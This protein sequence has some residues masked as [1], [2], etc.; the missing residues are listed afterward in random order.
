MDLSRCPKIITSL[1]GP[2]S[3]KLIARDE[4]YVSQSYTRVL[5]RG[6]RPC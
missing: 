3:K 4:K 5:S 2:K 1:P 6:D